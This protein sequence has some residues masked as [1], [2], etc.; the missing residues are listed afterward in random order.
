MTDGA[1]H[2]D[3]CLL[4][5]LNEQDE[6]SA[7]RLLGEIVSQHADPII[8]G[9]IARQT[10][11]EA[12]HRGA[13]GRRQESEDLQ[14]QTVLQLVARLQTLRQGDGS[15]TAGPIT[16]L[17]GYVAVLAFHTCHAWLRRRFPRRTRLKNRLRYLLSRDARFLLR[18]FAGGGW[19]CGLTDRDARAMRT[20]DGEGRPDEGPEAAQTDGDPAG[21][22]ASGLVAASA[23]PS[24]RELAVLARD[25][26]ARAGRPVDLESL[27]DAVAQSCG[28]DDSPARQTA[29]GHDLDRL[30]MPQPGGE[31]GPEA[32]LDRRES[33]RRI[34]E[35]ILL[36]P[37]LQRSALL[38]NLRDTQGR[39]LIGLF[40]VTGVAGIRR[41]ATALGMLPEAFASLW[42]ELPLDD[43]TIAVRLRLSRQQ[44]IN[45]RKSA[46]KR[47]TRRMNTSGK[48]P[49][50]SASS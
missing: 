35:E 50:R 37:P 5:Y 28:L 18:P 22:S 43:A 30:P 13:G 14:G 15:G 33:L 6:E 1:P 40:P 45:L 24:A 2:N 36:L 9:V 16:D 21:E 27:V 3:P 25:L 48:M 49:P 4:P 34:W 23:D 26:L 11:A 46:R 44:V 12:G 32:A 31:A 7:R 38:L 29:V 17:R 20:D 19:R 10:R 8:K 42:K 41:I 39:G 47:L